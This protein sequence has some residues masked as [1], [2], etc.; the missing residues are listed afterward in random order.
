MEAIPVDIDSRL[1]L[2]RPEYPVILEAE[3]VWSADVRDQ[4]EQ[5]VSERQREPELLQA[6]LLPTKSALFTGG[7]GLGAAP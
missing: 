3:P 7:P 2:A 1:Q 4:L 5:I 6:S